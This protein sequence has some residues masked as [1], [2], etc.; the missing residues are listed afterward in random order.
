VDEDKA[1]AAAEE[2]L[3]QQAVAAQVDVL[4]F[5]GVMTRDTHA[6]AIDPVEMSR[7][8][9]EAIGTSLTIR[10]KAFTLL[11]SDLQVLHRDDVQRVLD[12]SGLSEEDKR[13]LLEA[14]GEPIVLATDHQVE[15]PEEITD[16]H[17]DERV[18]PYRFGVQTKMLLIGAS[19]GLGKTHQLR[20]YLKRNSHLK[21]VAIITARQQQAYSAQA[22]FDEIHWKDGSCGFKHYLDYPNGSLRGFDKIIVQHESLHRLRGLDGDIEPYDLVIIDEFRSALTQSQCAATNQERLLLNYEILA[23]LLKYSRSICLD[24][25]MEVDG[26]VWELVSQ[27]LSKEHIHFHRY[28]HVALHRTVV[29]MPEPEWLRMAT[30]DLARGK[31]IGIPCRSKAKMNAVLGM[32]EFDGYTKLQFDSDST[33]NHM[34]KLKDINGKLTTYRRWRSRARSPRPPTSKPSLRLSTHTARHRPARPLVMSCR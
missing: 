9:S 14:M 17:D 2:Y 28:T 11:P 16:E 25:D 22:V 8:A 33:K 31:R 6:T 10:E 5:D 29:V 7:C 34:E 18:L 4:M 1:I 21:R 13:A 24:A 15:I 26:A 3:Q 32:A 19:M 12:V 30:E 27:L 20:A 23:G